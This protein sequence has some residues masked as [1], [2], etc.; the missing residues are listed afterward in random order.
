MT[1]PV[2]YVPFETT[3]APPVPPPRAAAPTSSGSTTCR[4]SWRSRSA[5]R[6]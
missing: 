2:D 6:A 5:A 1:D 4:S 3:V